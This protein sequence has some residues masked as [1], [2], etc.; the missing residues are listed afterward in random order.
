MK[1][2]L[3][4]VFILFIIATLYVS[5]GNPQQNTP[6]TPELIGPCEGCEAIFEYGEKKLKPI[7]TLPGFEDSE[8]KLKIYGTIFMPDGKTPAKDVILYVYH[9]NS[10]GIYPTRGDETNWGRRHGY[11]RGWV[12]TDDSGRYAFYTS[13]PGAYPGWTEPAHIHPIILQNDGKYYWI[14]EYIFDDDSLITDKHR[15]KDNPRGGHSGVVELQKENGM[16]VVRR[17]IVLE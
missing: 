3:S 16:W 6:N 10:E 17:D 5:C 2:F 12:K 7:D 1:Y 8:E 11:I 13:R 4:K 14:E 15:N 9:T